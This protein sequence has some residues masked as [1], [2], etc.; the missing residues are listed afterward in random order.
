MDYQLND[1]YILICLLTFAGLDILF[2]SLAFGRIESAAIDIAIFSWVYS[3]LKLLDQLLY[4]GTALNMWIIRSFCSLIV[5]LGLVMLHKY[6]RNK[7]EKVIRG[8]FSNLNSTL[9]SIEKKDLLR[10]EESLAVWAIDLALLES[11]PDKKDRRS[12]LIRI[13]KDSKLD[14][15]NILNKDP[16]L[17]GFNLRRSMI[18]VFLILGVIA[19]LIPVINFSN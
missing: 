4:P 6:L 5:L 3:C 17:L 11:K 9:M 2:R 10:V 18:A 7:F 16:F 19:I 8:V 12:E 1:L 14:P 15:N 13:L